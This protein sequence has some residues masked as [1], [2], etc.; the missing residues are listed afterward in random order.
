MS[1]KR[2]DISEYTLKTQANNMYINLKTGKIYLYTDNKISFVRNTYTIEDIYKYL[3][4]NSLVTIT[5]DNIALYYEFMSDEDLE[6][7]GT[8]IDEIL[9]DRLLQITQE[10]N[11]GSDILLGSS[12]VTTNT[13]GD[14]TIFLNIDAFHIKDTLKPIDEYIAEIKASSEYKEYIFNEEYYN[15]DLNS[16]NDL[17][18]F[19]T[20]YESGHINAMTHI[21]ILRSI[22]QRIKHNYIANKFV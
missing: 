2:L 13:K 10:L 17:K 4:K 3:L 6:K 7:C 9:Q 22:A 18:S 16:W 11:I 21:D 5:K 8:L 19:V 20:K 1:K 12:T 15:L 14:D